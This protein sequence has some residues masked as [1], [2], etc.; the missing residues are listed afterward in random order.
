MLASLIPSIRPRHILKN[1]FDRW[2]T[3]FQIDVTRMLPGKGDHAVARRYCYQRIRH[4]IQEM[5]FFAPNTC[6]HC[7]CE[8]HKHLV[9]RCSIFE[10][11]MANVVDLDSDVELDTEDA[12]ICSAGGVVCKDV[13]RQGHQLGD[14]GPHITSQHAYGAERSWRLETLQFSECTED[15]NPEVLAEDLPSNFK[16]WTTLICPTQL[17]D[18][19]KKKRRYTWSINTD[20]VADNMFVVYV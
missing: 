3:A 8:L 14:C 9:P 4:K 1:L 6:R 15:H 20:K 19:M 12:L 7:E 2:P 18:L 13:T 5:F 17:G 10:T 11:Q 16:P